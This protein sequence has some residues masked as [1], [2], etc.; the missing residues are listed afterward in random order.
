MKN[1]TEE[2]VRKIL[3]SVLLY[4]NG[5]GDIK[6]I[7]GRNYG[8][9]ADTIIKANSDIADTGKSMISAIGNFT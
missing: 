3:V 4:A 2:E 5:G 8:E 7:K 6:K 1:Y 9:M